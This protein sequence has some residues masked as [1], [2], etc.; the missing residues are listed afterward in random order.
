V[1]NL[2]NWH[3]NAQEPLRILSCFVFEVDERERLAHEAS[4]AEINF[5]LAQEMRGR[6]VVD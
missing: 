1:W 5:N 4:A 6:M 3:K 2:P